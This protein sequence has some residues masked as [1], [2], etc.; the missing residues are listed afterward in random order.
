MGIPVSTHD[1]VLDDIQTYTDHEDNLT[2]VLANVTA[3]LKQ[4]R[5]RYSWV[6]FYLFDQDAQTMMLGPYQGPPTCT[7]RIPIDAGMCGLAAR[8]RHTI[9]LG[10]VRTD[11]RYIACSP[12]VRSEI[13]VPL[14]DEERIFGVLDIDSDELNAFG[15]DDRCLLETVVRYVITKYRQSPPTRP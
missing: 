14:L 15:Q 6:G 7:T 12:T 13:I 10:D 11:P 9:V 5:P 3:V 8:E 2:A 1:Q 4:H